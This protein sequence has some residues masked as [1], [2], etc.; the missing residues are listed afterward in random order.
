MPI[1]SSKSWCPI[2]GTTSVFWSASCSTCRIVR[3]GPA[4]ISRSRPSRPSGSFAAPA[5][6]NRE[7][8]KTRRQSREAAAAET[9]KIGP[10]AIFRRRPFCAM[11]NGIGFT[12]REK[13]RRDGKRKR[14]CWTETDDVSIAAENRLD[15]IRNRAGKARRTAA[16]NPV[17]CRKLLARRAGAEYWNFVT[18]HGADTAILDALKTHARRA[19]RQAALRLTPIGRRRVRG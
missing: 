19:R 6:R 11:P 4:A 16:E 1:I 8:A 7:T 9:A 13:R 5:P 18:L 14:R 12:N 15:T 3:D 17:P 2:S 10:L